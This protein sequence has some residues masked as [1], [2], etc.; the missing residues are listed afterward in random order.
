[1][2]QPNPRTLY[3]LKSAA[4]FL[5]A[6]DAETPHSPSGLRLW[7]DQ[8]RITCV[9]LNDGER[10]IRGSELIRLSQREGAR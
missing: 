3:K 4:D 6:A 9:R 2:S 5:R 7:A 8:G 10:V 1:M